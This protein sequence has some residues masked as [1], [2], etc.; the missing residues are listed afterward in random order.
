MS[1]GAT[2]VERNQAMSTRDDAL[3][4]APAILLAVLLLAAFS[5]ASP[6]VQEQGTGAAVEEHAQALA[7]IDKAELNR[8]V[9]SAVNKSIRPLERE[10]GDL[11]DEIRLHDILGGIGY[12]MGLAGL[13]FFFLGARKRRGATPEP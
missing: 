5:Q 1:S 2:R 9:E 8:L 4:P 7:G 12:I 10:I 3:V 11:K 6:A 13:A